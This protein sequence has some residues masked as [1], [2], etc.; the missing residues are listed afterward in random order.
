MPEKEEVKYLT[1]D[2]LSYLERRMT[3]LESKLKLLIATLIDKKVIGE[4][5]GKTLVSETDSKA[6]RW[7]QKQKG[8]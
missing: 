5:F 8:D 6:I 1:R 3:K 2:D 4:D 7:L